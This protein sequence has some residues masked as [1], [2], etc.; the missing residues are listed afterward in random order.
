MVLSSGWVP[1]DETLLL[2]LLNGDWEMTTSYFVI[3]FTFFWWRYSMKSF[4]ISPHIFIIVIIII[5]VAQ[6]IHLL[7]DVIIYVFHYSF[8]CSNWPKL[9]QYE[10]LRD[11]SYVF[12]TSPQGFEHF[13]AGMTRHSRRTLYS[14]FSSPGISHLSKEFW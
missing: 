14:P 7:F 11:G 3:P 2:Q 4:P 9:D 5:W 8:W 1:T 13:H 10:L 6:W 12:L